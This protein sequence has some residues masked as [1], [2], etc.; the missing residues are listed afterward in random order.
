MNRPNNI[1]PHNFLTLGT[2][3]NYSPGWEGAQECQN[4]MG[5]GCSVILPTCEGGGNAGNPLSTP[6]FLRFPTR[7]CK[8][9]RFYIIW[10]SRFR[11]LRHLAVHLDCIFGVGYPKKYSEQY[12]I[13]PSL[14]KLK[15]NKSTGREFLLSACC[16]G[17]WVW[18]CDP[19][20]CHQMLCLVPAE[21]TSAHWPP[22]FRA[23]KKGKERE[24]ENKSLIWC[25]SAASTV[26]THKLQGFIQASLS[27][28]VG[29]K[30][31][32]HEMIQVEKCK[33]IQNRN[34]ET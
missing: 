12:E 15:E 9:R 33:S 11:G 25:A 17:R 6:V 29:L 27:D 3:A 10:F 2:F 34:K 24:F 21:E 31:P 1:F 22:V 32:W 5:R 19:C 4:T 23:R 20:L 14:A 8:L 30:N 18:T 7:F 13:H 16:A 26:M 28:N